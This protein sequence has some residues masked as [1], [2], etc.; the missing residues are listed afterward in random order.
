MSAFKIKSA[1]KTAKVTTV[2]S[3]NN[4]KFMQN[5]N[6]LNLKLTPIN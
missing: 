3:S 4:I 5:N 6:N 1:N 2:K